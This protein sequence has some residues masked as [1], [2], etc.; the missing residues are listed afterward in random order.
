MKRSVIEKKKPAA[1]KPPPNTTKRQST[2][3][4]CVEAIV[5][6]RYEAYTGPKE[7]ASTT[8]FYKSLVKK[9]RAKYSELGM[10]VLSE[11]RSLWSH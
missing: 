9:V 10:N 4:L 5:H 8:S 3:P 1:K 11:V 6:A 2:I 7:K